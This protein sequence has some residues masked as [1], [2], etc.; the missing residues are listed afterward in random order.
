[1]SIA[2]FCDVMALLRKAP[3]TVPEIVKV[4]GLA[5]G[6]IQ[7]YVDALHAEGH[8]RISKLRPSLKGGP[9]SHEYE[10]QEGLWAKPDETEVTRESATTEATAA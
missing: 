2:N 9:P 1:V 8:V 10:W 3:R 5:R 7:S 4:T 6:T